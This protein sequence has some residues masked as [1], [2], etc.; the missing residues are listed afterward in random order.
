[1][2]PPGPPVFL[3]FLQLVFF[4]G[5][6]LLDAPLFSFSWGD[7]AAPLGGRLNMDTLCPYSPYPQAPIY[8]GHPFTLWYSSGAWNSE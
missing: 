4:V 7:F 1:M 5:H 3:H 6:G 8:G 2:W